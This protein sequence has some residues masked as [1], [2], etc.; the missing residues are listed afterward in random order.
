MGGA[1]AGSPL[2][3]CL[4]SGMPLDEVVEQNLLAGVVRGWGRV[5]YGVGSCYCGVVPTEVG[6]LRGKCTPLDEVVEQ[7]L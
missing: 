2:A 7:N 5:M 6:G 3:A 1:S 4:K